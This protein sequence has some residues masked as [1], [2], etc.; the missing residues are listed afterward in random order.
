MSSSLV[1]FSQW[2]SEFMNSVIFKTPRYSTVLWVKIHAKP[3]TQQLSEAMIEIRNHYSP[4]YQIFNGNEKKT[5]YLSLSKTTISKTVSA[6]YCFP[7]NL[8]FTVISVTGR[9]L[10]PELLTHLWQMLSLNSLLQT[11][12]HWGNPVI[13]LSEEIMMAFFSLICFTCV[14]P[15]LKGRKGVCFLNTNW[16]PFLMFSNLVT[17][18]AVLKRK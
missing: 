14:V 12:H 2:K 11:L 9:R 7:S 15:N 10:T 13:Y 3:K 17:K 16:E 1:H 18:A 4:G 5:F 8:L 6:I